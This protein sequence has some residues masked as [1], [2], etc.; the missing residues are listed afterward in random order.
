MTAPEEPDRR[1]GHNLL[2]VLLLVAGVQVLA[3]LSVL[4]L[5]TLAPAVAPS[6]GIGAHFVGYQV[7]VIY[8][9]AAIISLLAGSLVSR[10]GAITTS[11]CAMA[12]CLV[13]VLGLTAGNLL[14]LVLSSLLIGAGYGLTNPAASHLLFR[15]A[16]AKHRNLLFSLKQ[17]AV[18]IGGVIAGLLLP[19]LT[20]ASGWR[21]AL[22]A[23]AGL[24][25]A[26]FLVLNRYRH[27]FDRDRSPSR[28][29]MQSIQYG[30]RVLFRRKELLRLSVMAFCF[31]ATQLS[32]MSFAVSL[33]VQDLGK[34]LI[35]AGTVVS[36]VQGCGAGGRIL[37]G[38]IADRFGAGIP[39]L[40]GIGILSTLAS[41]GVAVVNERWPFAAVIALLCVYGACS[42]GWNGVFLAE[43]ARI[44][45]DEAVSSMTGMVLCFTFLG[46]VVGP[47][48]FALTYSHLASYTST[49]GVMALFPAVGTVSLFSVRTSKT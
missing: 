28:P 24:V 27:R 26:L 18:P 29:L 49:Y 22:L 20:A 34:S 23:C 19:A 21:S 11:Q 9:S 30:L 3:T 16:P 44:S 46:V 1:P 7:S 12:L 14:V 8:I 17:T 47:T 4:S 15:L 25:V 42:I 6:F 2:L 5:A 36:L 39:V 32:L 13:G 40:V 33:L 37:W 48:V 45:K 41:L 10:W 31:S 35:I 38:I 43:V